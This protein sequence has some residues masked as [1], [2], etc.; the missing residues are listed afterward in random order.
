MMIT[1]SR[2]TSPELVRALDEATRGSQRILW[3]G[4]GENPYG[5]FLAAADAFIVTADS[6]NMVGEAAGTGK[7]IYVFEP[8]GGSRKFRAF[9]EALRMRGV[10]RPLPQTFISLATWSYEPLDAARLIAAEIERRWQRRCAMLGGL[11][12]ESEARS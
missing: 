11:V 5:H 4:G 3:E 1:P 12:D 7:P 2:R 6:V 9:H 10:T 8:E